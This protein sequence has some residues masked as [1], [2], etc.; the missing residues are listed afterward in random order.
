ME[1]IDK[2]FLIIGAGWRV[3]EFI[4][5]ALKCCSIEPK[6]I[7]ILRKSTP[8]YSGILSDIEQLNSSSEL[9]ENYELILNCAPAEI[10]LDLQTSAL[11]MYPN[12]INF[13]DTPVISSLFQYTKARRLSRKFQM[14]SLEDWP[15]M[16]NLQPLE[17][18][19]KVSK[20]A[21]HFKFMHF[22]VA[23]HFLSATRKLMQHRIEDRK[24]RI[25]RSKT[26]LQ[27]ETVN[28]NELSFA[29][30]L[31]KDPTKSKISAWDGEN[32]LEDFFELTTDSN[33]NLATTDG[34]TIWRR[35]QSDKVLYFHGNKCFFEA[36]IT[37][38]IYQSLCK[39]NDRM[40]VHQLDKIMGLT[41]IIGSALTGDVEGYSYLASAG[42]ATIDKLSRRLR[43]FNINL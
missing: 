25:K 2:K 40:S 14:F 5:P 24:F 12:A 35:A 15:Y 3:K 8:E 23:T 20:K 18:F 37:S 31:P 4:I 28:G 30:I 17:N 1:K 41:R 27:L 26:A 39:M 32:L 42:D 13:C 34:E 36:P 11:E 19:A 6:N 10:M 38:D 9:K 33:A 29:H 43:R 21:M 16:P 7:C 22:G